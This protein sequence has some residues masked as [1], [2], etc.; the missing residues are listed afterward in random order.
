VPKLTLPLTKALHL[1]LSVL[2][3]LLFTS[4]PRVP[5]AIETGTGYDLSKPIYREVRVIELRLPDGVPPIR[6][7]TSLAVGEGELYIADGDRARVLVFDLEGNF[8]RQIGNGKRIAPYQIPIE[9]VQDND[10]WLKKEELPPE[11]EQ[12]YEKREFFR[13]LGVRYF[14]GRVFILTDYIS[15][16]AKQTLYKPGIWIYTPEGEFE[17]EIKLVNAMGP[18]LDVSEGSAAVA[19]RWMLGVEVHSA[20][21]GKLLGIL[22]MKMSFRQLI[23]N[24][25]AVEESRRE[26][27]IKGIVNS[28]TDLGKFGGLMG[29]VDIFHGKVLV[30]DPGNSRIQILRLDASPMQSIDGLE[31]GV[32]RFKTPLLVEV[33]P[34][35]EIFVWDY[36]LRQFSLLNPDFSLAYQFGYGKVENPVDM[37]YAEGLGLLVLDSKGRVH[38]FAKARINPRTGEVIE[39][40]GGSE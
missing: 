31:E 18:F 19:D 32:V 5:S 29:G 35:G 12:W 24:L 2:A 25:A 39:T 15:S 8:R 10:I 36:T 27:Y 20:E 3:L 22:G 28:G 21:S 37:Q 14:E 34:E 13:P 9:A 7:A 26:A 23:R 11:L 16:G 38:L 4:C 40:G 1:A 17:D 30:A 33:S 6:Q